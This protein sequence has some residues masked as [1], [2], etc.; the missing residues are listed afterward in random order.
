MMAAKQEW[1]KSGGDSSM[2]LKA[3]M[4]IILVVIAVTSAN[5]F[6]SLNFTTSN[7]NAM[8]SRDQTLVRDIANAYISSQIDSL[9]KETD[10]VTSNLL[11]AES[12]DEWQGIMKEWLDKSQHFLAFSVVSRDGI[13]ASY[14]DSPA[15]FA[16]VSETAYLTRA[17]NGT[18]SI[19]TTVRDTYSGGMV[20]YLY[21]P[22]SADM[23]M[24]ATLPGMF[25]TDL[26]ADYR[27]WVT[28]TIYMIDDEGTLIA[29]YERDRVTT[30]KN[31]IELGKTDADYTSAGNFFEK[32][33][34]DREGTG[35][36]TLYGQ[37]RLCSYKQITNPA[38]NWVVAVMAPLNESPRAN[39]QHGLIIS[40]LIFI[41]AGM[42][43]AFF[44]SGLVVKPFV[45]IENQN[46]AL[47]EL[48]KTVGEQTARLQDEHERVKL[49]FDA[50]PLACSLWNAD[51]DMILCND[52]C[53]RLF[54]VDSK[55]EFKALFFSMLSPEYQPDGRRSAEGIIE[56]IDIVFAKGG[57]TC[58]WMH[59]TKNGEPLP[60]E[61]TIVLVKYEG[62]DILAAYIRDMRE[63]KEMMGQI[64]ERDQLLE[65]ALEEAQKA[66]HA[67]SD[68]LAK[69]S[70]EMRTPLNAII[71][72]STLALEN[73]I[74]DECRSNIEKVNNAGAVLIRTVND[75]LDISKIEAGK[76]ELILTEYSISSLINDVASQSSMYLG[77]KPIEFVLNIDERLP[78]NMIGD[79]LRIKQIFNNLLSNAFKYTNEGMVTFEVNCTVEGD[80]V[81]LTA[82]VRDTGVG[83]KTDDVGSLFSDYS[84]VDSKKNR[85]ILGT[86]LGLSIVKKLLELMQGTIVVES[87]Y[88][89]GSS[90]RVMIPQKFVSEEVI[91]A[92]TV[93]SLSNLKYTEQK[94]QNEAKLLRI[95]LPY[96]RILIVD[97]V[98]ANLDVAKGLMKPYGMKIDCLTNG[99]MAIEAVKNDAVFYDA[100][101]LDQ[102]MPEMDGIETI[103]HI[104]EIGTDYAKNIPIIAL[105]ANAIAGSEKMFLNC[106]FNAFI[107]KPIEMSRLD[108]VIRDWVRD[109]EKE[110]LFFEEQKNSAGQARI[111]MMDTE[112]RKQSDRRSGI[113]R[114]AAKRGIDGIDLNNGIERFGGDTAIYFEVLRSFSVNTPPLLDS[115]KR[116]SRDNLQ[117]YAILVHGIKGSSRGICA[118]ELGDI[119]EKLEKAADENDFDYVIKHNRVF[120]DAAWRLI[121]DIDRLLSENDSNNVKP[122][123]DKP[124]KELLDKLVLACKNYDMDG[125]DKAVSELQRY[126]Y[127]SGGEM[128]EWLRENVEMM[129]FSVIVKKLSDSTLENGE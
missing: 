5:Y 99:K 44:V 94:R 127:K 32:M 12:K 101:F 123:M 112:R 83:I 51:Y 108:A 37:E 82:N 8:M 67:K 120:L 58:E 39:V 72:L 97:D 54:A 66:N 55:E 81:W 41:I 43:I 114:R 115:A 65:E 126:D 76:Y 2:R 117:D 14:G 119:A 110:R 105:T 70:H 26:L 84:Q 62:R 61:L 95:S 125:A 63:Y 100:I 128:I 80:I 71:G 18:S 34:A 124:D 116:V 73:E 28:G 36:Y 19:S 91:G 111:D 122:K 60:T 10:F 64:E 89:K 121:A 56:I 57:Y 25:F 33:I 9:I 42:L 103:R 24:I 50:T 75:I 86:G 47:E 74:P 113:E 87:E 68:F 1:F 16:A 20:F 15:G 78:K 69:M 6:S 93:I 22:M 17:F 11:C 109:K 129:N 96:A 4:L 102:M 88:G 35:V 27:L 98:V 79:E 46:A 38:V 53:V 21:V 48:N 49:M 52:E 90:F 118:N 106:G 7:I 92:E 31:F 104:R 77:S 107:S 59:Q 3:A 30:R 85:S 40:A 13:I 23:I 29:H 45:R